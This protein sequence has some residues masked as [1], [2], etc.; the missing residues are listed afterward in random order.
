M[1]PG[2][3][4]C[5]PSSSRVSALEAGASTARKP[6]IQVLGGE[7]EREL[8]GGPPRLRTATESGHGRVRAMPVLLGRRAPLCE[9][10]ESGCDQQRPVRAPEGFAE[11]LNGAAIGGDGALEVA[12]ERYVVLERRI[13]AVARVTTSISGLP[14]RL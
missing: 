9:P 4:G 12:R 14:V 2:W 1:S 13:T 5:H 6:A 8:G 3:V 11:C 7:G 10:E